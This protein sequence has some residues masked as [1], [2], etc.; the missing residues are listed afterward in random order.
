MGSN[1]VLTPS[2][3]W[4]SDR[5]ASNARFVAE[6]GEPLIDLLAPRPGE[7]ILDLGCGDGALTH[8]IA[9]CG[10]RVVGVDA[11]ESQVSAARRLGIDV[12]VMDG[13]VLAVKG[14]VDGVFSN[15][16]LHWMPRA[17][18]VIDGVWGALKP[19]GRFVGEMGGAGNIAAIAG[20]LTAAMHRH[21]LDGAA[22]FPWYF[23]TAEAY[24]DRLV[25]RGFHVSSISLIPRPTPLPGDIADWLDTFAES[26]LLA[27]PAQDRGDFVGEI[28]DT[29]RPAL[30]DEDGTWVADYVRLRFSAVRPVETDC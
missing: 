17:D 11:S 14:V 2:Q 30:M 7:L 13:H 18:E 29:L 1:D 19:G 3:R 21:G 8:K 5:Y 20:A 23:P 9:N 6:L 28:R 27:V 26:F 4:D 15:A 16:A 10:A 22:A 12:A 25:E 24:R